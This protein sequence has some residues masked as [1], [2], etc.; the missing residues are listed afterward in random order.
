MVFFY[1]YAKLIAYLVNIIRFCAVFPL[2]CDSYA[3]PHSI[4]CLN[5]I[6][7]QEGC[8]SVSD[9]YP[10]KLTSSQKNSLETQ[11]LK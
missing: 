1:I 11:N 7:L 4:E 9:N 5:E 3:G 2:S 8:L 6:W 10:E